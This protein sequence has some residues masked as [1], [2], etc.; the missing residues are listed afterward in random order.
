MSKDWLARW[1]DN[2]SEWSDMSM[3]GLLFQCAGLMAE[4]LIKEQ[5]C[6]TLVLFSLFGK[7]I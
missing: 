1:Q 4:T 2:V 7:R 3:R 6:L 5:Q